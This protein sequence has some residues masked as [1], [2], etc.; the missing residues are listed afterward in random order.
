VHA[1]LTIELGSL[2]SLE[3]EQLGLRQY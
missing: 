1:Y 2:K 3:I